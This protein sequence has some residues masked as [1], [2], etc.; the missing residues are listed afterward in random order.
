MVANGKRLCMVTFEVYFDRAFKS[1]E[2]YLEYGFEKAA[3]WWHWGRLC[4]VSDCWDTEYSESVELC[5]A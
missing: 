1:A 4:M 2:F 5:S 3:S